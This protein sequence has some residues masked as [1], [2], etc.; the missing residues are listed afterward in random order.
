M[1][2]WTYFKASYLTAQ[3]GETRIYLLE[4]E[5]KMDASYTVNEYKCCFLNWTENTV[6][7]QLK[8]SIQ[9]K[10]KAR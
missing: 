9:I 10:T 5:L 8:R 6:K 2:I 4:A 3:R 1:K 7:F